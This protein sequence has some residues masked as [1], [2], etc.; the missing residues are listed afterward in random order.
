MRGPTI[1]A[2]QD[3]ELLF[4]E[5][6]TVYEKRTAGPG[7]RRKMIPMSAMCTAPA[8]TPAPS[9]TTGVTALMRR[10]CLLPSRDVKSVLYDMLPL[11]RW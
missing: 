10:R 11:A 4:G 5:I 2:R 6:F 1:A 9:P 7:A 8:W 3:S